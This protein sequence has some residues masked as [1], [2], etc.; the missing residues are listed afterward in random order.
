MKAVEFKNQNVIIAEHQDE[1]TSLPAHVD[2]NIGTVTMCFELDDDEI[3]E[4]NSSRKLWLTLWTFNKAMQPI[5]GTTECPFDD[6][7]DTDVKSFRD[8]LNKL[9][10]LDHL[11]SGGD[12]IGRALVTV[13]KLYIDVNPYGTVLDLLDKAYSIIEE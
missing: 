4:L 10:A 8:L 7:P 12:H 1:Y 2:R 11:G 9:D 13:L 3:I 5:L 6:E